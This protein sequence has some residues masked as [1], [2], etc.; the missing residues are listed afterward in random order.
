[1]SLTW[2]ALSLRQAIKRMGFHRSVL[3]SLFRQKQVWRGKF[4]NV[5]SVSLDVDFC[6]TEDRKTQDNDA[7]LIMR[8]KFHGDILT[9]VLAGLDWQPRAGPKQKRL[10][11]A[12]LIPLISLGN[13]LVA[14]VNLWTWGPC[15]LYCWY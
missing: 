1:M 2:Y 15:A 4:C 6:W 9:L 13:D 8:Y 5:F 14:Y 12:E 7:C 11:K 10:Y 3:S